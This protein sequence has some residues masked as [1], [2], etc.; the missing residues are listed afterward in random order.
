MLKIEPVVFQLC[1]ETPEDLN[2][3]RN[4]INS[5][6]IR[7]HVNIPICDPAIAHFT[8]EDGEMLNAM[9]RELSV[10]VRLEKKGQD[11]VITLEGLK[12]DVQIADSRIRDMIRKV[13]RNG[14]RRN[15]A[16]LISSMVQW[17][18]QENGWSVSNFDIFT[19]YELEQ[20]YQNRQPTLRIK[21]NND[22]YEADLVYKEATRSQIKIKLNRD[23]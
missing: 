19:N 17:Q 10:S 20:A 5:S 4:M 15:V 21:I 16:I 22:E 14:N 7:E 2:E 6:I 3:A 8:R 13:D 1:G 23:L 9:Q 11:S 12:R 18:Y